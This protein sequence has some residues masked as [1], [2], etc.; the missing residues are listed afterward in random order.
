MTTVKKKASVAKS[1]TPKVRRPSPFVYERVFIS[2]F[3]KLAKRVDELKTGSDNL[4]RRFDVLFALWQNTVQARAGNTPAPKDAV[5]GP[6]PSTPNPSPA[7]ITPPTPA[8]I[9]SRCP[10]GL[11]RGFWAMGETKPCKRTDQHIHHVTAGG[12]IWNDGARWGRILKDG[13]WTRP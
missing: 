8:P 5:A 10:H 1:K 9:P 12:V 11:A 13:V 3:N 2:A 4:E 6:L 7:K